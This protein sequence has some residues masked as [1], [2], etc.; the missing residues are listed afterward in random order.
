MKRALNVTALLAM[1]FLVATSPAS[2][3]YALAGSSIRPSNCA[4]T[5]TGTSGGQLTVGALGASDVDS[6]K[7]YEYR[8]VPT[9]VFLP[10]FNLFSTGSKVDFNLFGYNVGR[11]DQRYNGWFNTSAFDL[12]YDYN[13]IPHSM[14]NAAHTIQAELSEGVWGMSD[15]LQQSLGTTVNATP[16]A[17]RIV[18]FYDTLLGPTFASAGSVDVTSVRKRGAAKL[19]FGKKLPFDLTFTYMRELKS[20]YRGEEGGA[21]TAP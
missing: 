12:S 4:I 10:C 9:G 18:T 17:N 14:G 21:S 6:S 8:D 20:G 15:T 11:T 2:A 7:F 1:G 19:D 13:Q 3:Q 16:T 5:G